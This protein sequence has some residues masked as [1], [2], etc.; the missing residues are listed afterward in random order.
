VKVFDSLAPLYS[1]HKHLPTFKDVWNQ[2]DF[3][4]WLEAAH[5]T[6]AD[7]E[8]LYTL[9]DACS[10]D[11]GG[12]DAASI[13]SVLRARAIQTPP[14]FLVPGMIPRGAVSLLL[15]NKKVGKSAIAMELAVN[16]AQR[17]PEWLGFPIGKNELR[18]FAVYLCGEDSE[19]QAMER[20]LSMSGG[21]NPML[22]QIIPADGTEIDS[23]LS[24]LGKQKVDLLVVDPA[25]KYFKGDEDGSDAVSDF[26]T[27]L[28]T[29]A[30]AKQCAVVVLHHLKRNASPQNLA[31]VARQYRGSSVFLDRPRVTLAMLRRN[32]ETHFGIPAPDG[33]PLHNFRQSTMFSDVKRLRRDEATFRHVLLGGQPAAPKET[34]ASDIERVWRA[35]SRL[36]SEGQRVTRTGKAAVFERK[37][38]EAAGLSR[39]T[40]RDA[41]DRLVSDGRLCCDAQSALTLPIETNTKCDKIEQRDKFDRG[42]AMDFLA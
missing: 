34:A 23:L 9:S 37:A 4:R 16:V 29:F 32:D 33:A 25:R 17:E 10:G 6:A 3:P 31:D 12:G 18:G 21:V 19:E 7:F 22:L 26:F 30:R 24:R 35:I 28:E 27:K 13:A 42:A 36:L 39:A 20:I 1:E 14:S 38:P 8:L 40:V 15:G 5:A 41:V 11:E 2:G